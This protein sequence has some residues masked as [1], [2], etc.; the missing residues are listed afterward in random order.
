ML[1]GPALFYKCP[2]C[3]RLTTKG[4]LLSGNTF[5]AILYSD[6]KQI[7][8]MLPDF[9]EI[10]KCKKCKTFFW[11]YEEN[12]INCDSNDADKAEFLS[13]YE[14]Y[15]AINSN[16]Y[17]NKNELKFLKINLWWT[18]NDRIRE[19]KDLFLKE[20]DKEIYE[21]NCFDL[22]N[23]LKQNNINN[24]IMAAELNRN[25]GKFDE[26]KSILE[27]IKDEEYNW[28]IELLETECSKNNKDNIILRQ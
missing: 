23:I 1:Y 5:G 28:I 19:N 10:V 6:G 20:N 11:L 22:I 3:E 8:P 17:N 26:C 21:Q 24:K 16:V 7:A 12:E 13:V 18:F 9:P 15:E 25:L 2:K 14:Y 27:S 4:S